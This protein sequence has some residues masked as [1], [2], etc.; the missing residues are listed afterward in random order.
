MIRY[1]SSSPDRSREDSQANMVAGG[2]VAIAVADSQPLHSRYTVAAVAAA[3][4]LQ[5]VARPS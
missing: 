3:A 1:Y 2:A 5:P 4:G